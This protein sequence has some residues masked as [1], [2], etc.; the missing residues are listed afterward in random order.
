MFNFFNRKKE[1][2]PIGEVFSDLTTNQKMSIMNLLLIIGVCDA[3]QGNQEKELQY[4]NTYVEILNVRSDKSMTYL[5]T[6]GKGRIIEDLRYLTKN[7][8]EFLIVATWEMICCD[9]EANDTELEFLGT[10]FEKLGVSE[11]QF[12]AIQIK[13][14]R[15]KFKATEIFNTCEGGISI[16]TSEYKPISNEGCFEAIIFNSLI[17]LEKVQINH[18][19]EYHSI[20]SHFFVL[21]LEEAKNVLI[22]TNQDT[23]IDFIDS[24]YQFFS[25]EL[26]KLYTSETSYP[27]GIYHVFFEKPLNIEP[28]MSSDLMEILLFYRP[29]TLMMKY[30]SLSTENI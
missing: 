20:S 24:R 22:S 16:M 11:E 18:T 6:Y 7:Q 5:E 3:K 8:K 26:Q 13:M 15:Q 30:V 12:I 14:D 10:I 9:G 28:E 17:A 2:N 27:N 29:L 4:L 19:S 25:N 1:D 23:L 21:L